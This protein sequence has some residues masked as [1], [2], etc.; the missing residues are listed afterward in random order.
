MVTSQRWQHTHCEILK[1]LTRGHPISQGCREPTDPLWVSPCLKTTSDHHRDPPF[2]DSSD[3]FPSCPTTVLRPEPYLDSSAPS[4]Y[5]V[6]LCAFPTSLME[7]RGR[8]WL[9]LEESFRPEP[10]MPL[11]LFSLCEVPEEGGGA[12]L[13]QQLPRSMQ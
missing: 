2:N 8:T 11:V 3:A 4:M 7:G 1:K 12:S 6:E 9:H 13:L 5:K 10:W